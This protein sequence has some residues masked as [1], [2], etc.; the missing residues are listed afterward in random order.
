MVDLLLN[1]FQFLLFFKYHLFLLPELFF[2][3]VNIFVFQKVFDFS[4]RHIQRP[5][6]AYGIQHFKLFR[7]II[8]VAGIRRDIGWS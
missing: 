7:P 1:A 8:S 4:Q 5:Q 6:I 2:Y 3:Q